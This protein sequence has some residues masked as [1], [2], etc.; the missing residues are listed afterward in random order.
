MNM[1]SEHFNSAAFNPPAAA[2][3]VEILRGVVVCVSPHQLVCVLIHSFMMPCH[4]S[5]TLLLR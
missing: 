2:F 5:T 3:V 1:V 4:S